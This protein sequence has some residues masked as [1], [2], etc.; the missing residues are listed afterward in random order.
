MQLI[1]N[2]SKKKVS[3][4]AY[5]RNDQVSRTKYKSFLTLREEIAKVQRLGIHL[6]LNILTI[7]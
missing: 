7:F 2:E 5:L 4:L 1:Q 6:A 3:P